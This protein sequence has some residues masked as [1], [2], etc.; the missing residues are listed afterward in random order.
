VFRRVKWNVGSN[1]AEL[2]HFI[3]GIFSSKHLVIHYRGDDDD[4]DYDVDGND[5]NNDIHL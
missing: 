4:D 5:S 1:L 3:V 2:A